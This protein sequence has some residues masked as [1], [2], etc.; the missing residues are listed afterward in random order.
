MDQAISQLFSVARDR[1]YVLEQLLRVEVRGSLGSA[2]EHDVP[3]FSQEL[4]P[5]WFQPFST[6]QELI[7]AVTE[8]GDGWQQQLPC[9]SD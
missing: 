3:F 1:S 8:L 7:Q 4:Y 9:Q 2:A 6:E 5:S